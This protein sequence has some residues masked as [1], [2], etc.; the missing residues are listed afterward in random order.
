MPELPWLSVPSITKGGGLLTSGRRFLWPLA[1]FFQGPSTDRHFIPND[2]NNLSAYEESKGAPS[3]LAFILSAPT[4][5][6][7]LVK[8]ESGNKKVLDLPIFF[9][10]AKQIALFVITENHA[11]LLLANL[12]PCHKF[13]R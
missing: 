6:D 10:K 7:P 12:A 4:P 3:L 13:A 11:K 5:I 1:C 9:L 2:K 8:S